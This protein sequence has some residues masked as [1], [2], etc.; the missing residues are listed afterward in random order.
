MKSQYNHFIL[1]AY[2]SPNL[3]THTPIRRCKFVKMIFK[4]NYIRNAGGKV[5]SEMCSPFLKHSKLTEREK[6]AIRCGIRSIEYFYRAH[7]IQSKIDNIFRHLMPINFFVYLM[8]TEERNE[9]WWGE[10]KMKRKNSSKKNFFTLNLWMIDE[11]IYAKQFIVYRVN[12][13]R[14]VFVYI[15][16]FILFYFYWLICVDI[17]C[18]EHLE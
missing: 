14:F 16:R 11:Y 13:K 17:V 5:Y 7:L 1:N 6:Q 12:G 10:Q 9:V 4:C 18:I 15:N 3:S 8:L 2:N